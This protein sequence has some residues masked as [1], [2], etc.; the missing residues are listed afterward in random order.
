MKDKFKKKNM[1]KIKTN[2]III[3]NAIEN[4]LNKYYS[5]IPTIFEVFRGVLIVEC[6]VSEDI[7]CVCEK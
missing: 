7:V 4:K 3:N 1:N 2:S 6:D 5:H